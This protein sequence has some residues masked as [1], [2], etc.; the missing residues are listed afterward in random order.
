MVLVCAQNKKRSGDEQMDSG[1]VRLS[2]ND[3]AIYVVVSVRWK[4]A[5]LINADG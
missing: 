5:L 2:M 3:I 1:L 4:M